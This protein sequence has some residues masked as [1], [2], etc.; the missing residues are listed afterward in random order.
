M[1]L[2]LIVYRPETETQNK[3]D[4]L[5]LKFQQFI[6]IFY[7]HHLVKH[8]FSQTEIS[9]VQFQSSSFVQR[10]KS[11]P[12]KR[13]SKISWICMKTES[14]AYEIVAKSIKNMNTNNLNIKE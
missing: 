9:Y 14:H 2:Q 1:F 13:K 11:F 4:E 6:V 8:T 5:Y 7:R 12:F 3:N 10:S